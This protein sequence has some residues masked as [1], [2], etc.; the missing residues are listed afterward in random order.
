MSPA[1]S[2][3]NQSRQTPLS[4]L[5]YHFCG[6]DFLEQVAVHETTDDPKMFWRQGVHLS[7]RESMQRNWGRIQAVAQ[8]QYART[9]QPSSV[10]TRLVP[11]AWV[12]RVL[13]LPHHGVFSRSR[14]RV[15]Q[16]A[17]VLERLEGFVEHIE[18][19]T[20]YVTLK[21][22]NGDELTGEYAA[23]ELAAKGITEGRRFRCETVEIDGDVR[24][25]FEAVPD[26]PVTEDEEDAISGIIGELFQ[27]DEL[28]GDY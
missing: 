5:S 15:D 16:K 4:G 24:V 8:A 12:I 13:V 11:K 23:D 18:G 14:T 10:R 26:E 27:D 22:H 9:L 17:V 21:S 19:P 20:A 2:V 1:I 28:D 3:G 25:L 6:D 7:G